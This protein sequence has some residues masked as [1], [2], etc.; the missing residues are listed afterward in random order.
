MAD[1]VIVLKCGGI[2]VQVL[3]AITVFNVVHQSL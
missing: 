3:G 1:R 2:E